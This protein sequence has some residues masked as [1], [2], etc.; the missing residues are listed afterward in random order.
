VDVT[1][2]WARYKDAS[3]QCSLSRIW[4]GIHPPVDD[5]PGRFI[6][7]Q[8]GKDAFEYARTYF[9]KVITDVSGS[10]ESVPLSVYPNPSTGNIL[11]VHIETNERNMNVDI[12]D[13]VGQRLPVA[14]LQSDN[15]FQFDI[16]AI[17]DGLYIVRVK[18]SVKTVSQKVI[19]KRN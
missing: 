11:T 7:Q 8:I 19:I 3:D 16:S 13:Q 12:F 18:S 5:I 2:Q 4:G 9:T 14:M 1:L 17:P 10:P 15:T 6:G